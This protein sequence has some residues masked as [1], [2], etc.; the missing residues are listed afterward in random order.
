MTPGLVLARAAAL[1]G[2][3]LSDPADLGGSPRSTVLRA[4]TEKGGTVVVK[5]HHG[6][7]SAVACFANEVAGLEL[8]ERCGGP[9][10]RVLAVDAAA[11]LFVMSDL[12]AHSTL[13]DVLIGRDAAAAE[14]ALTDWIGA[15]G[16]MA[17]ATVGREESL[18]RRRSELGAPDADPAD[19]GWISEFCHRLPGLLESHGVEVPSGF[20]AELSELAELENDQRFPV[21]S[22]GDICADNNVLTPDG[23]RVLDFESAGYHS[24]FLDAAYTRMPFSSCWLVFRLP[25]AIAARLEAHYRAEVGAVHPGLADDEVWRSGV[26][27]AVVVWSLHL[28]E[29]ILTRAVQDDFPMHPKRRP[30][31]TARQ[32]LRYRWQFARRELAANDAL[33]C[34]AEALQRLLVATEHWDAA[35]L[36]HY[37][38]FRSPSR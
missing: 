8:L 20:A 2:C 24:A 22:P 15:Y 31:P 25:T 27:R 29:L 10:P 1:L 5:A 28:T 16:R 18:A 19:G 6:P 11:S 3:G 32:L 35:A 21:F 7:G 12:G 33:P 38:P 30:V 9:G 34:V 36:D 17:A 4:T 14:R 37:P 13:V 26:C 23:L